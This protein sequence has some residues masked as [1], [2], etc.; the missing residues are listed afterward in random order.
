MDMALFMVI[1]TEVCWGLWCVGQRRVRWLWPGRGGFRWILWWRRWLGGCRGWSLCHCIPTV[2]FSLR[3]GLGHRVRVA[4]KGRMGVKLQSGCIIFSLS[5]TVHSLT[6]TLINASFHG[7]RMPYSEVWRMIRCVRS[8]SRISKPA[9]S[10]RLQLH[11]LC[12][13]D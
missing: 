2:W 1:L 12:L 9:Q 11:I 13:Q 6:E 8:L 4:C 10:W 7:H 3:Y 5:V